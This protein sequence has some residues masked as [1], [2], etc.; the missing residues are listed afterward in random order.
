MKKNQKIIKLFVTLCC[1]R[2]V[3]LQ[4]VEDNSTPPKR[5]ELDILPPN[6]YRDVAPTVNNQP[7][8]VNIS[9]IVLNMVINPGATQVNIQ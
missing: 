5:N 1:L 3:L 2:T 9:I 4:S 8:M 6:Y 7:V